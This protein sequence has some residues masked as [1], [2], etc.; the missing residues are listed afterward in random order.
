MNTEDDN[1]KIS[2][3]DG[4][5]I[6]DAIDMEAGHSAYTPNAGGD[7][8]VHRLSGMFQNWFLDYASYVIL[9][10]AVPHLAD[11]LKPVQRRILYSM[12]RM[13]DGRYNK[14]ANIVGHTMQ[15]H[16]H[17]DASIYGALVQMGQKDLLIDCQG[18]WGNILTGDMAAAP[19]YIEAR[20]S[21]FALDVL[22][23]AKTTDWKLSYDG[24]NREPVTLPVKFPL[25]LAQGAEGIAVGLSAK[26]LPHNV[27]EICDAAIKYLHGEAFQ[28]FP[29]FQTGGNIDVSKY[30]D[31]RRGGTVKIRAKIEKKDNK[32]LLIKEIPFSKTTGG[33]IESITKAIG[34][35]KIKARKVDDYTS[36]NVE[37]AV[38]LVPG[39]SPDKTIDALYAFTD[40]EVSISPN[41][42]VI[43]EDKPCFLSV[44]DVLTHSVDTTKELL[45]KE[46]EIKRNEILEQLHYANLEE[47]FIN[48]R[49]YKDKEFENA[50]TMDDACIH[51]D[52]R[53]TPYYPHMVREVTKEDIL[54]LMEIKM[55]RILKFNKEKADEAILQM[56][57]DIAKIDKDLGNMVEVTCNW[58]Q[59]IKDKYAAS[60]PRRTEIRSFD[61]IEAS[62]VAEANQKLYI[63]RAEG[64]IGTALKKDEYVMPCSDLDQVILFYR[65][66]T[67][68]VVHIADKLFVGETEKSKAEGKKAD[69]IHIAVYK[70]NDS[71]TIYNAIYRD[72]KKGNTYVKRFNVPAVIND[73]EYDLTVGTP[74]SKVLYFS[75]NSN[76]EAEIVKV[77]LK[78][79][80]KLKKLSFDLDFAQ[81]I[82]KGRKSR[83][84]TVTKFQVQ[85]ILLKSHGVST[86]GGRKVWFDTAIHRL[87]YEE[88]GTYLGEFAGTDRILVILPNGD[89][90][91]TDFDLN[92]H[93]ETELLRI[94]KYEPEKVWTAVILDASS[95]NTPY[96]KRFSL[97]ASNKRQSLL[98]ENA[99]NQLALL[100][101]TAYPR[102]EL[103]FTPINTGKEGDKAVK[104]LKPEIIDAESFISVKGFKT[105][106]KRLTKFTVDKIEELEPVRFPEP[107]QAENEVSDDDNDGTPQNEDPQEDVSAAPDVSPD[108]QKSDDELFDEMTGQLRLF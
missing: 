87:N 8:S 75:A 94:E 63:N 6:E 60:H 90:Y 81:Q 98:G 106:G 66:G 33:I 17:G 21:K 89:F 92:N 50:P 93:Y 91:F 80:P 7:G 62:K 3:E 72:G 67:F 108:A 29:D 49:I 20:L 59:I 14:V 26:I 65:D 19:R 69:I 42:C 53:L 10:R 55:A 73:R 23:N 37:I 32:T 5:F 70:K 43:V 95:D 47:I 107:P 44:S 15:F 31:G 76:G 102:I 96:I 12:K 46:L 27:G 45:R 104:E 52:D 101:D 54:K 28:L 35:G 38:Q 25:L 86:L 57:K 84:N 11:G 103:T 78:P 97:E 24:R 1:D 100:S 83:G 56:K 16:P 2:P 82:I 40:C 34:K 79:S 85:R 41:C 36:E 74:G 77:L 9:D 99:Q 4:Q 51:I 71:R 13:D 61:T 105:R 58:F 88:R 39:T 30:N 18:S 68:K 22:F 64:F 48:E